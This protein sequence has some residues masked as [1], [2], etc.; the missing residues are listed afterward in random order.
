LLGSA[1]NIF[2]SQFAINQFS[3]NKSLLVQILEK[4]INQYLHFDTLL[5]GHLQQDDMVTAKQQIH[6]IKGISGNLGMQALHHACKEL[7]TGFVDQTF[8]N[9][10]ENFLH[11]FKQTLISVQKYS[12]DNNPQ[13]NPK[14]SPKPDLKVELV[15]ALKRNEFISESKMQH[16]SQSLNLSPEKQHELKQAIDDLD[17]TSAIELLE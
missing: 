15:G 9:I 16:Y 5:T 11:I 8:E 13:A 17:Y 6:T 7:E 12:E 10:L 3:G 2:D 1:L 14:T 4:F